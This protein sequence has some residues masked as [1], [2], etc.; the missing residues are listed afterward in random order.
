M[1]SLS[2]TQSDVRIGSHRLPGLLRE[3]P[4]SLAEHLRVIYRDYVFNSP[5]AL[6]ISVYLYSV[7]KVHSPWPQ[8]DVWMI[9][10]GLYLL[11]RLSVGLYYSR[12]PARDQAALSRW[13]RAA[14]AIQALDGLLLSM[15]ALFIYPSLDPVAQS[16]VLA[17]TLVLVGATAFSLSG[18]WLSIAVYAPPIYLSLAWMTWQQ[19]HAYSKGLAVFT[20]AMF[21]LYAVYANNQRKSVQKGFEIAKLNGELADQL[22]AKNAELEEVAQARSRLLATVSHDLRQPAHAIG[23][24]A[25]RALIDAS[26]AATRQ[27]LNDLN[28]L[29]QSLSASLSTLMDLTRLD[30]GL[31]EPRILPV[32][33]EHVLRRLQAEFESMARGKGLQLLI[34]S[35]SVWVLSD[36]VLLHGMLSNLVSNAIKYTSEGSVEVAVKVVGGQAC[37]AVRDS[38]MGIREDKLEL[39]FKEFV[40]LDAAESGSEGLGLGL[41]IVKRYGLLLGHRLSV[42]SQLGRGSRFSVYLPLTP[43]VLHETHTDHRLVPGE[44]SLAGLRILV[45]DNVHLL[46][47]SMIRTLSGWG[48][49]VYAARNLVEA[50]VVTREQAIHVVISDFHLGDLEPDGLQLI[51]AMRARSQQFLPAMLMTG[52]VSAQL[53]GRAHAQLVEVLHKPVRPTLLREGLLQLIEQAGRDGRTP[54]A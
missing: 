10:W 20:L 27:S 42:K 1:I 28:A 49:K 24:L 5:L 17:A 43:A 51:E 7:R 25:E 8:L 2:K 16:A 19:D 48:C 46:L 21:G 6:F 45:V 13:S 22:Q 37:V 12:S 29:S 35:S 14:I 26:P 54:Q 44:S 3:D 36:P 39:I 47:T 30:A 4:E 34:R 38:G 18:R 41:S 52:D 40:R 31:V 15:M 11:S 50:L 33:L 23:L 32:A 9:F 53:E